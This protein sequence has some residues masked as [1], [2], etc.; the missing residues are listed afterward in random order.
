MQ[1]DIGRPSPFLVRNIALLPPGKAL[2]I[3]MGSG[4]NALYLASKGFAVDGVEISAERVAEAEAEALRLGL[5]M[6]AIVADLEAGY[7]I[8]LGSYDLIIC[9][10]YLQRSL[11]PGVKAGLRTGGVVVYE[12]FTI[13][14]RRFGKPSN[15]DFLLKHGELKDAF[16]EFECL[17]YF[18]GI[19][20]KRKAV[21]RIIARKT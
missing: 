5:P 6:N 17:R 3:A 14:Q 20:G 21:A 15:P 12:T 7:E 10:N 19:I 4:R 1:N 16:K 8:A 13:D 18:E 11:F 2:D 9:F